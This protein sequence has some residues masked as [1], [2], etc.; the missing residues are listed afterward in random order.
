MKYLFFFLTLLFI[1]C[2]NPNEPENNTREVVFPSELKVI[3][4]SESEVVIRMENTCGSA[5]WVNF[6]DE[7]TQE[8]NVF[9]LQTTTENEGIICTDQCVSYKRN[10]SIQI[11]EAGEY[12]FNYIVSDTV[13]KS[14]SLTF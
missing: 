3:Q 8:G 10:Y 1:N 7:V 12:I 4:K 6:K 13:A 2:S 14:L 9:R 5:C 11:S